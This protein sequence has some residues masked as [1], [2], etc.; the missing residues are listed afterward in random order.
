MD[1]IIVPFSP[2]DQELAD[3]MAAIINAVS[4]NQTDILIDILCYG[5]AYAGSED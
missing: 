4:K 3:A 5:E 2:D 1:W